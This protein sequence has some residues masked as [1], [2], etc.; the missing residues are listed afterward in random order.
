MVRHRSGD[1]QVYSR[2]Y[3]PKDAGGRGEEC[4]G[5]PNKRSASRSCGCAAT[6]PRVILDSCAWI[7]VRT[8]DLMNCGCAGQNGMWVEVMQADRAGVVQPVSREWRN[9]ALADRIRQLDGLRGLAVSMIVVQHYVAQTSPP[10]LSVALG[11]LQLFSGVDL[12]F[13]LSGS[14]LAAFCWS[15]R[16]APTTSQH[17]MHAA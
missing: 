7:P 13:V 14:S 8:W 1:P 2:A 6:A 10:P 16:T 17:F 15:R 11:R 3:S 12:F 9:P 5:P 4:F